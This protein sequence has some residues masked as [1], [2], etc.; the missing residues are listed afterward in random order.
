VG[1]LICA[2]NK[3]SFSSFSYR[4]KF[5][6]GADEGGARARTA[7][8]LLRPR[9]VSMTCGAA[10]T[11]RGMETC[12][13]G[14]AGKKASSHWTAPRDPLSAGDGPLAAGSAA[15]TGR[16]VARAGLAAAPIPRKHRAHHG[17]VRTH[18]AVSGPRTHA[19]HGIGSG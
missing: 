7:G 18:A 11:E 14:H 16:Q 9:H 1:K 12:T 15:G 19:P 10:V 17:P 2:I 4:G 13:R 8:W 5:W 3:Q 6:C